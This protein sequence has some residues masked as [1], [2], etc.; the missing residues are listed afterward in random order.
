MMTTTT[1]LLLMLTIVNCQ[2]LKPAD[3]E[4]REPDRAA[5]HEYDDSR[6]GRRLAA[7]NIRPDDDDDD[8]DDDGDYDEVDDAGVRWLLLAAASAVG[9]TSLVTMF[10]WC[11]C[12]PPY[13]KRHRYEIVMET[14][15]KC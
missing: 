13:R 10:A 6:H 8:D 11:T 9:V 7:Y 4:L 3:V 5:V 12:C 1:T 14:R 2:P 15:P